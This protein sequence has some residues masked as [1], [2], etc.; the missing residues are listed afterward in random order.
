MKD[1]EEVERMGLH[2][3]VERLSSAGSPEGSALITAT[4]IA[5]MARGAEMSSG[6]QEAESSARPR[7][8]C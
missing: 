4:K 3:Q 6:K 5:Q 2:E 7:G 8:G 1:L